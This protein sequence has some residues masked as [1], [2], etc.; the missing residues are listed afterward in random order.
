MANFARCEHCQQSQPA[1]G[2]CSCTSMIRILAYLLQAVAISQSAAPDGNDLLEPMSVGMEKAHQ[3]RQKESLS[4]SKWL[5][6]QVIATIYAFEL[7]WTRLHRYRGYNYSCNSIHND[8]LG[9]HLVETEND[10]TGRQTFPFFF[11]INYYSLFFSGVYLRKWGKWSNDW[12][13][14]IFFHGTFAY[15][16]AF[17]LFSW[18]TSR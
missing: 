18:L 1:C 6:K 12:L 16:L 8:W 4:T 7:Q 9:V 13:A 11:D 10:G 3:I 14:Q 2:S 17:G 5:P 15:V